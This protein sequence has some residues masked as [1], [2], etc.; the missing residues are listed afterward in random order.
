MLG[1]QF[2][3]YS[4]PYHKIKDFISD[5]LVYTFLR[6]SKQITKSHTITWQKLVK[7]VIN[8]RQLTL[9]N[10]HLL[11]QKKHV[12]QEYI[13]AVQK[14]FIEQKKNTKTKNYLCMRMA[15]YSSVLRQL[16]Y[17]LRNKRRYI[18]QYQI[19]NLKNLKNKITCIKSK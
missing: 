10:Y 5:S 15:K 12:F 16:H 8:E 6:H 3:F 2:K 7:D 9:I 13:H 17:H 19:F 14:E 1:L 18:N 4:I 11:D